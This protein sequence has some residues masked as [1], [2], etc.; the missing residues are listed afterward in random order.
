MTIGM[1]GARVD[2]Y[3]ISQGKL[4]N[5]LKN[6]T[7][8]LVD[9]YFFHVFSTQEPYLNWW[10]PRVADIIAED[11]AQVVNCVKREMQKGITSTIYAVGNEPN[12]FPSMSPQDYAQLYSGYYR[13]IKRVNPHANVAMGNLFPTELVAPED[14]DAIGSMMVTHGVNEYNKALDAFIASKDDWIIATVFLGTAGL[15][16]PAYY[17]FSAYGELATKRA[18]RDLRDQIKY[19]LA[20]QYPTMRDYFKAVLNALPMNNAPD[21]VSYHIYAYDQ[22]A[23]WD[24]YKLSSQVYYSVR[25]CMIPFYEKYGYTPWHLI[26][27]FGNIVP[28]L[29]EYQLLQRTQDMTDVFTNKFRNYWTWTGGPSG[30]TNPTYA[31]YFY[32]P[33]GIDDQFTNLPINPPF[34]R[35]VSDPNFNLAPYLNNGLSIPC[36]NLNSL[37]QYFHQII[38]SSPC[39]F[40]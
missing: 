7:K 19:R 35:M 16:M 23:K 4:A 34:S 17:L 24:D 2:L 3:G 32:K 37:G 28:D 15:A 20:T 18:V 33:F 9:W 29:S 1:L 25:G 5:F 36:S 10:A 40:P 22:V 6:Y 30:P 21:F 38:N 27:E 39:R 8:D 26:T 12:L 31:A 11:S 13:I 14:L